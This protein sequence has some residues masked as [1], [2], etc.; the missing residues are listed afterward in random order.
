MTCLHQTV[1]TLQT[2]VYNEWFTKLFSFLPSP[3]L[4]WD[5]SSIWYT[6]NDVLQDPGDSFHLI[7]IYQSCKQR[8]PKQKESVLDYDIH[9][10]FWLSV[11][12]TDQRP[13]SHKHLYSFDR[14]RSTQEYL[15]YKRGNDLNELEF[16]FHWYS[17][18]QADT[19]WNADQNVPMGS[20][21]SC[22]PWTNCC[23]FVLEFFFH[24]LDF[25]VFLHHI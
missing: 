20:S 10:L 22:E 4:F 7:L 23:T 3:F 17:P 14:E 13:I 5:A 24:C 1:S 11:F 15:I 6:M 9:V 18:A 12:S 16:E 21:T 2:C 25:S 19:L 8:E